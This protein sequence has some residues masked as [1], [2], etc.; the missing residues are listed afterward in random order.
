MK[1]YEIFIASLAIV[2]IGGWFVWLIVHTYQQEKSESKMQNEYAAS[3][4]LPGTPIEHKLVCMVNN[5]YMGSDQI[6]VSIQNKT[7]YG[8]C[9]KC[10]KDLNTDESV[11]FAIDPLTKSKV[12]KALAFITMSPKEAGNVLYFESEQA[13]KKYLQK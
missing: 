12:D 4:P 3:L 8:C 10:V 13:A 9:D 6:P 11:R 7:Y 5:R 2:A 1:L